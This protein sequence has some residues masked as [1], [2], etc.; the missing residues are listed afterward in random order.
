MARCRGPRNR[1]ASP[2]PRCRRSTLRYWRHG[3]L[4]VTG[5][6]THTGVEHRSH[7]TVGWMSAPVWLAT[8]LHRT[9]DVDRQSVSCRRAPYT[10]GAAA[11]CMPRIPAAPKR[12]HPTRTTAPRIQS[13]GDTSS[14]IS[15]YPH[16]LRPMVTSASVQVRGRSWSPPS[17]RA[18]RQSRRPN[19]KS[20]SPI[21][22]PARE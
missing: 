14:T 17:R 8:V 19:A 3:S 5:A 11:V 6:V 22:S 4:T 7:S 10:R 9:R 18:F 20:K 2:S 1:L 13:P 15:E 21:R 12:R 16:S